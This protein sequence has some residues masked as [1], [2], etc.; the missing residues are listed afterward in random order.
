MRIFGW[1][2]A[3]MR[4]SVVTPIARSPALSLPFSCI[5]VWVPRLRRGV[6]PFPANECPA[7]NNSTI[8]E[9]TKTYFSQPAGDPRFGPRTRFVGLH[10]LRFHNT[11]WVLRVGTEIVCQ[12]I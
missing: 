10:W 12:S 6:L 5:R 1:S 7:R 9:L 4:V 2:R 8:T 11:T 3:R